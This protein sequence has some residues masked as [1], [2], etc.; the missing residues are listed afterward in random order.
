VPAQR[1][2]GRAPRRRATPAATAISP[3]AHMS[4]SWRPVNG[5]VSGLAF[6][7]SAIGWLAVS[8]ATDGAAESSWLARAACSAAPRALAPPRFRAPA[9]R[10]AALAAEALPA[11]DALDAL[12]DAPAGAA[13]C[14]AA[15]AAGAAGACAGA[16]A[17]GAAAGAFGAGA[18]A[19]T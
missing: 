4:A 1:R 14:G 10:F 8:A 6:S 3:T 5:S 11:L 13:C 16:G 18:G 19:G 12:W 2:A 9:S 7:G 17:A 15:G